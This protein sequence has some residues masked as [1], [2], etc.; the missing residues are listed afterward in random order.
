MDWKAAIDLQTERVREVLAGIRPEDSD[1]FLEMLRSARRIF[2]VGRGRTGYIVGTF[3][4]RLMHMGYD[5][6][7]IGDCTTPRIRNADLLVAVTGSGLTRMVLH[8]AQIARRADARSVFL[9]YNPSALASAEGDLIVHVPAPLLR[10]SPKMKE[11]LL[12]PLGTLFEEA[13]MFYL[14]LIVWL[15]MVREGITEEEMAARHTNLE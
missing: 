8:M 13:L 1:R 2:L 4:M 15:I 3:A 7:L 14:D 11:P 5:V 6:H 10:E 9:T 12:H